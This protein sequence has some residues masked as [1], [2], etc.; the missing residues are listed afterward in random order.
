VIGGGQAG[1]SMSHQL[2]ARSIDH[3]VLERHRIAHSWRAERWD[4]LRLLTPN[5]LT[6]LPGAPYVGD[7]PDG[8]MTA[9]EVVD[10][11]N[12]YGSTIEAP[13]IEHTAVHAVE[14]HGDDRSFWH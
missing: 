8:F 9:S 2:T 7:D 10:Q 6:R 5:W 1:L 11:L 14:P 12:E 3:V 13:V 4:S